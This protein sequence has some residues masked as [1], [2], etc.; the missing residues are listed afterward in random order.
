MPDLIDTDTPQS[1]R[2]RTGFDGQEYDLVFSDEFNVDG[3]TFYPGTSFHH[4]PLS[5]AAVSAAAVLS[6]LSL[7]LN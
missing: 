6:L 7:S 4:Y 2:S 3:R 5:T 1:A